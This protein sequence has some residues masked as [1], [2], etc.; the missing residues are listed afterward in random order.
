MKKLALKNY[1]TSLDHKLL[2]AKLVLDLIYHDF[3]GLS[4]V[5]TLNST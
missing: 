4:S 3:S 5:T 1:M 2:V